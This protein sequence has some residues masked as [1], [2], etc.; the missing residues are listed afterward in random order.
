MSRYGALLGYPEEFRVKKRSKSI[1]S[2]EAP[3]SISETEKT[4]NNVHVLR[5]PELKL[6]LKRLNESKLKEGDS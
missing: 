5:I 1:D 2:Y 3:L 6:D 4:K